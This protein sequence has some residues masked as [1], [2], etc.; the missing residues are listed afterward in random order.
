MKHYDKSQL[1]NMK[2]DFMRW[3]PEWHVEVEA[4]DSVKHYGIREWDLMTAVE[5]DGEVDVFIHMEDRMII[6]TA[7]ESCFIREVR[8]DCSI[9]DELLTWEG[10]DCDYCEPII[11]Y[12][13]YV[14]EFGYPTQQGAK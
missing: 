11:S 10:D 2:P 6:E 1:D 14:N 12:F 7:D 9:D 5:T 3:L 4:P 13:Q 8:A